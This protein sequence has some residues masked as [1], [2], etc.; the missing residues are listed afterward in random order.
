MNKR[1]GSFEVKTVTVKG[2]NNGNML[3]I[4]SA[5]SGIGTLV[6]SLASGII[7][8]SYG[9]EWVFISGGLL[10]AASGYVYSKL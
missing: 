9:F 4:Y 10:V 1:I 2:N 8:V 3:G 5:V 6:G 7:A